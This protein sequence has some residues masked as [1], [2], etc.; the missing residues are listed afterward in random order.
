MS[1]STA[2]GR[3]FEHA[4]CPHD[5]FSCLRALVIKFHL[6]GANGFSS[7]AAPWPVTRIAL[8]KVI[9]VS[10]ILAEFRSR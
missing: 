6:S 9:A 3:I 10:K 5:P 2:R 4:V 7:P 8:Q 1:S